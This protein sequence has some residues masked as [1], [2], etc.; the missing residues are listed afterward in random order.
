MAVAFLGGKVKTRKVSPEFLKWVVGA[1][2]RFLPQYTFAVGYTW[3]VR[4]SEESIDDWVRRTT[5]MTV[6]GNVLRPVK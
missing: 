6:L 2:P 3:P 1:D 5:G 4:E